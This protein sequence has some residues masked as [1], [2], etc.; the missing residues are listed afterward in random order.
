LSISA[1]SLNRN[2][3]SCPSGWPEDFRQAESFA[4]Y[5]RDAF[6]SALLEIRASG[7]KTLPI[8]WRDGQGMDMLVAD[9]A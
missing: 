4:D 3:S 8:R 5:L 9:P 7:R 6:G 1:F 2:S